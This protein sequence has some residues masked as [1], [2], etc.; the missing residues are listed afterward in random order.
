MRARARPTNSERERERER[1]RWSRKSEQASG[2]GL[3]QFIRLR[4]LDGGRLEYAAASVA[5]ALV[6]YSTLQPV[7]TLARD[8]T[9]TAAVC[10]QSSALT[11]HSPTV[12]NGFWFTAS[13]ACRVCGKRCKKKWEKIRHRPQRGIGPASEF[14]VRAVRRELSFSKVVFPSLNT[15]NTHSRGYPNRP[16]GLVFHFFFYIILFVFLFY[17]AIERCTHAR[18]H[19]HWQQQTQ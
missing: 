2:N 17:S 8:S 15:T 6:R 7:H 12:G 5:C 18:A 19:N 14:G 16:G 1:A 4:A 9:F 13:R 11:T 10:A 3:R